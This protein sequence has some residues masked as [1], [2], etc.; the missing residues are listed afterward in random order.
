[1]D[2][3][4]LVNASQALAFLSFSGLMV[5][6]ARLRKSDFPAHLVAFA[7]M[8]LGTLLR[9]VTVYVYGVDVWGHWALILSSVARDVQIVGAL[10]FLRA[11][12]LQRCGEW[13]W[14]GALMAA[15]L[16]AAVLPP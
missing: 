14:L 11:V 4:H 1:M 3:W 2:K 5:C 9:E 7:L 8:L 16:F 12:T 6:L 13:V 10:L 15:L